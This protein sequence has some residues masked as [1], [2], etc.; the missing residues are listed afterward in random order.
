[1]FGPYRLIPI[2]RAF[3]SDGTVNG[4]PEMSSPG[5]VGKDFPTITAAIDRGIFP[6]DLLNFRGSIY[7]RG[8]WYR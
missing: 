5:V 6:R 8:N 1:M 4:L 3:S 7:A 2:V